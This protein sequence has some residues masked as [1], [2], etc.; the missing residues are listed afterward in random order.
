IVEQLAQSWRGVTG[1]TDGLND[2]PATELAGAAL[3][4]VRWT[5]WYVLGVF[6]AGM[7]ALRF[8]VTSP[9]GVALRRIRDNEARMRPRGDRTCH[10]KRAA[11]VIAGALAG[12][13]GALL[14]AEQRLVTPGD[15]GLATS[16]PVLLAVIIGGEATLWGPCVGAAIVVVLRDVL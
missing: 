13:A 15:L 5:T 16:V 7:A 12:V 2:I 11:F 8:L 3:G 6:L 10:Y 9:L 4:D 14:A 1:G